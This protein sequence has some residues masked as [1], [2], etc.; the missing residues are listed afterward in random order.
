MA[1]RQC[2]VTCTISFRSIMA[3]TTLVV[4][5]ERNVDLR[6]E[7]SEGRL[8]IPRI[9]SVT[10]LPGPHPPFTVLDAEGTEVTPITE[11]LRNL[12]LSDSGPNT[13]RSYGNGLLRWFRLLWLLE[14]NWDKATE[15]ETAILVGWLR[16]APNPQR[17]RSVGQAG[18]GT[19][20]LRTGKA[21][22]RSGYAPRTINHALSTVS[23]FYEFHAHHGR[24]PITNPVPVSPQR[25]RALAHRSPLEPKQVPNRARLRQKVPDR[26]PRSIPDAL[27]DELFAAMVC[28][29]DRALMEFYVSSGARAEELLGLTIEDVDWGG[30]RI[31]V[32]SKGTRDRQMIPASPQAFLHLA[33]YLEE[34]GV[35]GAGEPLWRTRRGTT[36]QLTYWAMRRIL[37]RANERLSTNW[38][39]HDLRHTAAARMA[40]SGKLTLPQVQAVLRHADIQTTGRYL[41]TRVEEIF[42]KLNEHYRQPRPQ[43]SYPS[44][45]DPADIA[46]VFGA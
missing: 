36:R 24:G 44:G 43:T 41:T 9:G 40:N 38:T 8:D 21:S 14:V 39:L 46:A 27:W 20:N 17:R 30:Q 35:P 5:E 28:E 19:I 33:N 29:R 31:Y 2:S 15:A 25:R 10:A 45:Y 7:L 42:D 6:Q 16:S 1:R 18:P 13:C 12:V 3:L 11:F 37:Q 22:L 34:A 4:I 26:P 23:S 32:V